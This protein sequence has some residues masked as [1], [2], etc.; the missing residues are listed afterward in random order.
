MLRLGITIAAS[1]ALAGC[2]G[3]ILSYGGDLSDA[4][5]RLGPASFSVYIHPKDDTLLIQRRMA[6][7]AAQDGAEINRIVART[8]LEPLNCTIGRAR[9]VLPGS[10]EVSFS[11]PSTINVRRLAEEQR[12]ALTTG[13]PIHP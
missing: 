11:C 13:E 10:W 5:V 12:A 4:Q 7:M 2:S 9:E 1:V 8:F 6:Q 3:R